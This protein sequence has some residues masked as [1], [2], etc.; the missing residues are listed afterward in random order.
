R[1]VSD[2]SQELANSRNGPDAHKSR[3]DAGDG[4][5]EEGS[6]R[7]GAELARLLLARDH[8]RRRAVVDAARVSGRDSAALAEGGAKR[9]ELLRARVGPRV[10][11]AL[12]PVDGD[13]L[14]REATCL[15]R[16]RPPPLRAEPERLPLPAPAAVP[17]GP[18]PTG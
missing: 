2:S 14:V 9:R 13:E 6:E 15:L 8:E 4:A 17:P 7:L 12:D 10:L 16:R 18:V 1:V 5:A 11:V 3:I